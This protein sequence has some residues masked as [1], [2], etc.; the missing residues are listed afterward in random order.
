MRTGGVTRTTVPT[1]PTNRQ[2]S[3]ADKKHRILQRRDAGAT[4]P[5]LQPQSVPPLQPPAPI[6]RRHRGEDRIDKAIGRVMQQ[7]APARPYLPRPGTM[8]RSGA[9]SV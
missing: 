4:L 1:F 5:Q 7:Y 9:S 8:A 6:L 2:R 3:V